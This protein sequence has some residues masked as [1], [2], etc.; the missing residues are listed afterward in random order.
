[1]TEDIFRIAIVA[2]VGLGALA[3]LIQAFVAIALFRRIG[4][5]QEAGAPLLERAKSVLDKVEPMM[6][7]VSALMERAGPAVDKAGP[8][9]EKAGPAVARRTPP[10]RNNAVRNVLRTDCLVS[11]A[12]LCPIRVYAISRRPRDRP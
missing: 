5:M 3:F 1:M 2:G 12:L 9:I 4:G 10:R 6:E 7:K 11:M 8:V